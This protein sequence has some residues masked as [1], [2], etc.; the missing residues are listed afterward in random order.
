MKKLSLMS[1]TIIHWFAL[2]VAQHLYHRQKTFHKLSRKKSWQPNIGVGL[3]MMQLRRLKLA[4]IKQNVLPKISHY[5]F[6]MAPQRI[7]GKVLFAS[8]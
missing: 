7:L 1:F 5:L 3:L 4:L 8:T 6:L 2:Q